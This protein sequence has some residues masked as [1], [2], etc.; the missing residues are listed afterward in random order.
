M[1][2]GSH[3]EVQP[4]T[5]PSTGDKRKTLPKNFDLG[6]LPSCRGKKAR[7]GLSQ[8]VKSSLPS[9]QPFV[10]IFYMDSSTP[11]MTNTSKTPP[12]KTTVL[13]SSQPCEKTPTNIIENEDLAWECFQIAV[14]DEDINICYDMSLKE[15]EYSGVH[16][17]FKVCVYLYFIFVQTIFPC[18]TI[19]CFLLFY[20]PCQNLSRHLGR[21]QDWIRRGSC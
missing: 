21:P 9:S 3:P 6:S 18:L 4:Q 14:L 2:E 10:H 8:V 15:F 20:R 13:A 11:I 16:D 7:H 5:C 12:S 19:F 17:L 1:G